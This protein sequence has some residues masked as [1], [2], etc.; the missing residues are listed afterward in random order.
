M[1]KRTTLTLL[2]ALLASS[3][4]AQTSVAVVDFEAVI[5]KSTKARA[6]LAEVGL[7]RKSKQES[8]TAMAE[9]F[10]QKQTEAQGRA[11]T[12]TEIERRNAG[13]ELERMQTDITRATEDAERAVQLR[14]NQVLADLNKQL[15]PLVQQMAI[16]RNLDL[17][18]QWGADVGIVFASKALDITDDVVAAYDATP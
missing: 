18:L 2:A 14:A 5:S 11:A 8:L 13:N 9:A 1:I 3:A 7:L 6:A 17:V 4:V 10:R 15:G 12:M 16:D